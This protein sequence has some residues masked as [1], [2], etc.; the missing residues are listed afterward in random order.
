MTKWKTA[1]D[2]LLAASK[3]ARP[4]SRHILINGA[5]DVAESM[6][7][8]YS[9]L[10]PNAVFTICNRTKERAQKL[11]QKMSKL[12]LDPNI[13]LGFEKAIHQKGFLYVSAPVFKHA[14]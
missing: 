14:L 6:I 7:E 4:A 2:S 8:A 13:P 9:A 1:G 10:F 3:L 12:Y 11:V 5:G